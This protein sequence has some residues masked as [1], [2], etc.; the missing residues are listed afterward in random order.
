LENYQ[1]ENKRDRAQWLSLLAKRHR[2]IPEG[3]DKDQVRLFAY[4]R[5][6]L[7]LF[8]LM[9]CRRA[10]L[11]VARRFRFAFLFVMHAVPRRVPQDRDG[12]P[13]LRRHAVPCDVYW[14]LVLPAGA[15][16]E[17]HSQ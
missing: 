6:R 11:L 8:L 12:Q 15:N 9:R 10:L 2:D 13:S 3:W 5:A 7:G 14:P 17:R 16:G 1:L 4:I